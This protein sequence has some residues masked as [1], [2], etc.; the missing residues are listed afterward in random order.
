M[1]IFFT[2]K[3]NYI[4]THNALKNAYFTERTFGYIILGGLIKS[5]AKEVVG[6]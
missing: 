4:R 3:Y 2:F 5:T 1:N 6:G